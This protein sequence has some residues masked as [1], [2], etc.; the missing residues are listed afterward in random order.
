M[1]SGELSQDIRY[2]FLNTLDHFACEYV[3]TLWTLQ[4]LDNK[5][6][7]ASENGRQSKRGEDEDEDEE[8]E[9]QLRGK[10]RYLRQLVQERVEFLTQ[11]RQDLVL[12]KEINK[13]YTHLLNRKKGVSTAPT[14][15]T[16]SRANGN[17]GNKKLLL[18]INLKEAQKRDL[19]HE[20]Q[21]KE[22]L[23]R[24]GN[25]KINGEGGDDARYCFCND[26][27]YG[28]MIAC[29][30][31]NCKLEWFHYA[32]VHINKPPSGKWYCSESCRKADSK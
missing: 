19:R 21:R 27:S 16:A 24:S 4:Y 14:T 15:T 10:A 23:K 20:K 31:E 26:V 8:L 7:G 28:P 13:R 9:V 2:S 5:C 25:T 6:E 18:K 22:Y 29:D 3:R 32:C 17:N 30:N 1:S 12:Q 11:Y